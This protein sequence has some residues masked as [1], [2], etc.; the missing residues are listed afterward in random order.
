M[1]TD[2]EQIEQWWQTLGDAQF[3]APPQ[4]LPPRSSDGDAHDAALAVIRNNG[5][6]PNIAYA[7]WPERGC[8]DAAGALTQ[9]ARFVTD[10]DEQVI[11]RKLQTVIKGY[12]IQRSG[13]SLVFT[14][15]HDR[16]AEDVDP[17]SPDA[18]TYLAELQANEPRGAID[19]SQQQ[20]CRRALA[21][22]SVS[23]TVKVGAFQLLKLAK[24]LT[25]EDLSLAT[26]E[27]SLGRAEAWQGNGIVL[28]VLARELLDRKHPDT[29]VFFN[30]V[31]TVLGGLELEN[32]DHPR[33]IAVLRER[34]LQGEDLRTFFRAEAASRGLTP[35]E[36][37]YEFA[38]EI[39][40]PSTQAKV[41]DLLSPMARHPL[42]ETHR[43]RTVIAMMRDERLPIWLRVEMTDHSELLLPHEL[44]EEERDLQA[45]YDSR[46]GLTLTEAR[47]LRAAWQ[48]ATVA[49]RT[50]ATDLPWRGPRFDKFVSLHDQL[51]LMATPSARQLEWWRAQLFDRGVTEP[52]LGFA[53]NLVFDAGRLTR[54]DLDELLTDWQQRL[55]VKPDKARRFN[56]GLVTLGIALASD[57]HPAAREFWRV[58]DSLTQDWAQDTKQILRGWYGEEA[59]L[60]ELWGK[61][62][63]GSI[64][65]STG[66]AALMARTRGISILDACMI[67]IDRALSERT[68]PYVRGTFATVVMA[69]GNDPVIAPLNQATSRIPGEYFGQQ[70]MRWANRALSMAE[71]EHLPEILRSWAVRDLER[72]SL[73]RNPKQ[74]LP[75]MGAASA[76]DA[77]NRIN[78][79]KQRIDTSIR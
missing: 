24:T 33:A 27:E 4:P 61:L 31:A 57:E 12:R 45:G 20:W 49:V 34:A 42:P 64:E 74:V 3:L 56:P 30:R 5:L 35:R 25:D 62:R 43:F 16:N 39:I 55:L 77:A 75:P 41:S 44:R 72:H 78:A 68:Q 11:Q 60:E 32:W 1:S 10:G 76:A 79:L 23:D 53:L 47:E 59:D 6:D 40:E 8:F 2:R 21:T 70:S 9:P 15:V 71:S 19:T 48:D 73:L 52:T 67:G 66:W 38:A 7:V 28:R 22:G 69:M 36:V 58:I 13:S 17:A 26:R 14:L 54:Q 46:H 65:V 51:E 18:A 50:A 63:K 29:D 37:G